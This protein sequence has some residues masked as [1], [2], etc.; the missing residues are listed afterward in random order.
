MRLLEQAQQE[1]KEYLVRT[2]QRELTE[3]ELWEQMRRIREE[4]ANELYPD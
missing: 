1:R 4:I 2:G 3:E